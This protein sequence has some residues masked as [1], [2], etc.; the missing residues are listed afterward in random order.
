MLRSGIRKGIVSV[1]GAAS[2]MTPAMALPALESRRQAHAGHGIGAVTMPAGDDNAKH[3]DP[4]CA[5]FAEYPAVDRIL[6]PMVGTMIATFGRIEQ[7]T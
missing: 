4:A 5:E 3:V 2:G 7:K 6:C 1:V